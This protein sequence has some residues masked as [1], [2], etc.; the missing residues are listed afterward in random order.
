MFLWWES[1]KRQ[2][3]LIFSFQYKRKKKQWYLRLVCRACKIL[4]N[5]WWQTVTFVF[6]CTFEIRIITFL[7]FFAF[8]VRNC[9][10]QQLTHDPLLHHHQT[11][12]S[13]KPQQWQFSLPLW[14]SPTPVCCCDSPTLCD[15]RASSLREACGKFI[16]SKCHSRQ[17]SSHSSMSGLRRRGQLETR[18]THSPGESSDGGGGSVS[19]VLYC[20]TEKCVCAWM[21]NQLL[22]TFNLLSGSSHLKCL[23]CAQKFE[24][25]LS[26]L[27][28][29]V[30]KGQLYL[31][32]CVATIVCWIEQFYIFCECEEAEIQTITYISSTASSGTFIQYFN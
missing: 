7:W 2:T 28:C 22:Y 10:H 5:W 29:P 18:M 16:L 21:I 32:Y 24:W 17:T 31:S 15:I 19:M 3:E 9:W 20:T 25:Q 11:T 12:V 13:K 27:S 1:N 23:L 26:H 8:V 6:L 14:C 4:V 30:K